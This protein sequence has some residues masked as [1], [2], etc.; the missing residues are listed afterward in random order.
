M[1]GL[2]EHGVWGT[3]HLT[4]DHVSQAGVGGKLDIPERLSL[5]CEGEGGIE[6]EGGDWPHGRSGGEKEIQD[7]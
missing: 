1:E 7:G 4:V 2:G 5:G 6:E 3:R